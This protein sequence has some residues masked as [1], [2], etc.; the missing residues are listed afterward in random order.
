[1]PVYFRELPESASPTDDSPPQIRTDA[2]VSLKDLQ[3]RPEPTTVTAQGMEVYLTNERPAVAAA[4]PKLKDKHSPAVTGVRRV[5]L[6]RN[7]DMNLWMQPGSGF[8]ESAN[9]KSASSAKAAGDKPPEPTNVQIRTLGPFTY[10]IGSDADRARFD[11]LPPGAGNLPDFVRV[12]RPQTR[13]P[14]A[15]V[16]D[17]L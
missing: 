3:S 15:V 12:V 10:N 1:G 6:P 9:A 14:G 13:G 17:Q 4:R 11:R 16:C 7:V 8:L 5:V 2:V